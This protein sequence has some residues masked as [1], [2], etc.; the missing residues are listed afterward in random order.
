MTPRHLRSIAWALTTALL[1][2]SC[3][4]TTSLA[5]PAGLP[6]GTIGTAFR[7]RWWHFYERGLSWSAAGRYAEAETD[8]RQCLRQRQT[9]SRYARTYGMHFVQCFAHRELGAVLL[10]LGRRD[11]AERE[12]RLSLAQEPS[13]KAEW[14]LRHLDGAPAPAADT[15][16]TPRH[17][18]I[19][20][21]S[22][23]AS[24]AERMQISGRIDGDGRPALWAMPPGG[25]AT[26]VSTDAHGGFTAH[27]AAGTIFVLGDAGGPDSAT[28][29]S[30]QLAK[31][32]AEIHL[33]I[34]GPDGNAVVRDGHAWYRWS[35]AAATALTELAVYDSD[36]DRLAGIGLSGVQ[37]AGT[38][39]VAIPGGEQV[40]RFRAR[41]KSGA[42]NTVERKVHSQP[43]P[44]QDRG[45]RATV[46]VLPLLA[47]RPG[48]MLAGDDPRLRSALVEDGRFRFVDLQADEI[49]AREL[50]LVDAGYVDRSTA[51]AAGRRLA[52]R[53][54][55]A[56]TMT[57][58]GHDAECFLRLIHCASGRLAASAD[59]YAEVDDD[60]SADSLFV[61]AA[62]RLR[63]AFP[64]SDGAVASDSHGSV[65]FAFGTRA[66]LMALMQVHIFAARP[67]PGPHKPPE[68]LAEV[69]TAEA[70]DAQGTV[71]SGTVL[72][73]GWGI[74][75]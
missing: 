20:L 74:S 14:L 58:N 68:A 31:P 69:T 56:A 28:A 36:G 63:Q 62:G 50:A 46:V 27:A 59:A 15:T 49:L 2:T 23:V 45:L 40:L 25:V 6:P 51:A 54:A 37:A 64:V 22:V 16:A 8:L 72:G 39:F 33:L 44:Q 41:A 60:K 65:R 71:R 9:D 26:R 53:Y 30:L 34:D 75:E 67:E 1:L 11:E 61:A 43:S 42:E 48:A 32:E 10:H 4:R 52:C 57:R 24:P 47:P 35:A 19:T 55:I 73:T 5:E 21:G 3:V 18:Q 7:N 13:A 66:G 38:L 17:E 29:P 12:L 70:D